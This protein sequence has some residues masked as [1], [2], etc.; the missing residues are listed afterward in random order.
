MLAV[1]LPAEQAGV[2]AP[3]SARADDSQHRGEHEAERDDVRH[4]DVA[5]HHGRGCLQ[6]GQ[7]VQK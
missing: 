1:A 7:R 3:I 4:R 5:G 6:T 2:E